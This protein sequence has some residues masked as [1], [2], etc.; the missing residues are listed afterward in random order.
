M[1]SRCMPCNTV[2]KIGISGGVVVSNGLMESARASCQLA[3]ETSGQWD[4][5]DNLA[6]GEVVVDRVKP[7]SQ[8][9]MT[10]SHSIA[11]WP[12]N[13][14][15]GRTTLHGPIQPHQS[16]TDDCRSVS[17][18]VIVTQPPQ[19]A[20]GRCVRPLPGRP[21]PWTRLAAFSPAVACSG[22][23][24]VIYYTLTADRDSGLMLLTARL[25]V[26]RWRLVLTASFSQI[27]C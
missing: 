2:D 3:V 21:A 11:I 13:A 20:V 5:I 15:D 8:S 22:R 7:T 25:S 27:F 23:T 19:P 4:Q 16:I 9:L 1:A 6:I 17:C 10:Q 26:C 18:D 14:T 24:L 12:E